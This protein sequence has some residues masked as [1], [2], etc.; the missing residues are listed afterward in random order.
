M[1]R[2]ISLATVAFAGVLLAGCNTILGSSSLDEGPRSFLVGGASS[3]DI[4][5]GLGDRDHKLA[6][7]AEYRA[8]EYGRT[9]A[10]TAW[11][12]KKSGHHGEVTPGAGYKVNNSDCRD[13]THI[14]Y[15]DGPP[16]S[17][18]GTACRQADGSWT[19]VS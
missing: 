3:G 5:T 1:A 12:N 9:G 16:K 10:V 15:D 2:A 14:I 17:G 8:L 7:E 13:Y 4:G 11:Q 6:A 18:R 19:P